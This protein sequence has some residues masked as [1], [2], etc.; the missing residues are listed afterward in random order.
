MIQIVSIYTHVSVWTGKY[1]M[2]WLLIRRFTEGDFAFLNEHF[3]MSQTI[4]IHCDAYLAIICILLLF[5]FENYL[6]FWNVLKCFEMMKS[7]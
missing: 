1:Q 2:R 5:A 6:N 3:E 7:D 4:M